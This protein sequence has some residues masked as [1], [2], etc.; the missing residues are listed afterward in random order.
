[1]LQSYALTVH[2]TNINSQETIFNNFKRLLSD[3]IIVLH[4]LSQKAIF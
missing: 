1:M 3:I 4:P 2:Q